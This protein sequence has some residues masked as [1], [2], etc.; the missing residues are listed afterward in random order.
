MFKNSYSVSILK[1]DLSAGLVVFLVA[2]PL[3]L[4]IALAS[5][6]P[7]FSGIIAGVIGGV[8]VGILSGSPLSASGPAAGLTVIVL[9]AIQDLQSFPTFLLAVV[10]CGALQICFGLMKLGNIANYFPSGVIKGMLAAIGAILILKQIPHA[11]GYDKDFEGDFSFLQP[12]NENSF[13]MIFHALSKTNLDAIII[14]ITSIIVLIIWEGAFFKKHL[15]IIPGPLVVVFL[16][17]GLNKLFASTGTMLVLEKNHLVQLPFFDF[18]NGIGDLLTTPFY[19]KIGNPQVWKVGITLA[20]VASLE[21]LLGIDAVDKLDPHKRNSPK[22][23]ELMAQGVGNI[24]SGAIGGLPLTSVVV[25]S[26]ANV[27][28]GGQTKVSVIAHGIYIAIAILLFPELLNLIPLAS[29]AAILLMVG[30]K[31]CSPKVVKSMYHMGREQFVP[32]ITC[33][34]AI[35]FTDL[36][37]GICIG[38]IAGL[39]YILSRGIKRPF[40]LGKMVIK[41]ENPIILS[42]PEEVN[43]LNKSSVASTLEQIPDNSKVIIDGSKSYY[44]DQDVLEV[45]SDYITKAASKNIQVSTKSIDV[46]EKKFKRRKLHILQDSYD[47]IFRNNKV[48]VEEKTMADPEFFSSKYATQTPKFLYI[49]CSDSRVTPNEMTGTEPGDMFVH[50]N[51]ANVIDPTDQNFLSVLQYSIHVLKVKHILVCGHYG[52]G[53]VK[54]AVDNL[55]LTGPLNYWLESIRKVHKDSLVYLEQYKDKAEYEKKMVELNVK[56]QVKNLLSIDIVKDALNE[57]SDLSIHS[58]VYDMNT[59]LIKELKD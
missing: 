51:I 7:L 4:G 47:D 45:I 49:G 53:G 40:N 43:F 9:H 57:R 32:F 1:Q 59:G 17:I 26:S 38:M 56:A 58:M 23:R 34:F 39:G 44:I 46:K 50:R 18:R 15:S 25:R 28:S 42:L 12:D 35:L 52:C 6:A 21:T 8:V 19:N 36:L 31:L 3:C 14:S 33:F 11:I 13:T 5:G 16:G 24:F 27:A 20:I 48:W 29:L 41:K 30:Y 10:I 2:V 54:A 22:N 37:I 55:P